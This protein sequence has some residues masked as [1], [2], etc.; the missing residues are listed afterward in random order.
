MPDKNR[1]WI[2][3]KRPEGPLTDDCFELRE[4]PVPTPKPGE[5]VVRN[6][7]LSCD[8]TQR[9][10]IEIDTYLP[11][12]PLG[13]VVRGAAAGKV[14]ASQ[15]PDWAVGD[16]VQGGF[17]WQD[18]C[19]T[20]GKGPLGAIKLPPGV[21]FET[22]LSLFGITGLTAYFGVV[23]VAAVKAGDTVVVSGAAGSTGSL[24]AQ[25]AK[26][27]GAKVIG[28]AGG[29]KKKAWLTGELKLDAGIDYKSEDVSARIKA[30]APKG[31]NVYFDNVGGTILEA[32]LD[33]LAIGAR[34]ALCGAIAGYDDRS[35][36]HGPANYTNLIINRATMRG[37]L[38]LDY[39]DRAMEAVGRLMQWSGEG[40]LVNAVDV[41]QGLEQT[42]KAFRN[43][44][45]GGN[46]GK[47]LVRIA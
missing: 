29:A 10:W 36:A 26:N 1:Q 20:D 41:A 38:V 42:P 4:S 47:Q 28:I 5:F 14:V 39:L 30:L 33:N 21:P 7:V 12:I 3:V 13:D 16:A 27:L 31:L 23:D 6:E 17:G 15:H 2:L 37:F 35:K 46:L 34:I 44:F 8:P 25:I 32:A 24:A 18:Y 22:A 9:A 11:K 40:K 19:V 45:T 43:L